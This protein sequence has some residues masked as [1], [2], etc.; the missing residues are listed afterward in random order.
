MI[1]PYVSG[2]G[3]SER[4]AKKQAKTA[5]FITYLSFHCQ[6]GATNRRLCRLPT[7]PQFQKGVRRARTQ[8]HLLHCLSKTNDGKEL[9]SKATKLNTTLQDQLAVAKTKRANSSI[10]TNDQ[11]GPNSL[12]KQQLLP[13]SNSPSCFRRLD[14]GLPLV[15]PFHLY[16]GLFS[17]FLIDRLAPSLYSWQFTH[18]VFLLAS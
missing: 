12:F 18:P 7:L 9:H 14:W 16:S 8:L 17:W 11:T 3:A 5:S 13:I 10:Q 2:R 6:N 1:S 15:F 4:S